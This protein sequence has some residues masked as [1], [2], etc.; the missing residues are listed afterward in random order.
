MRKAGIIAADILQEVCAQAKAGV[1]L[2]ELDDLAETLCY[3]NDV[4]PAFKGFEGF[5]NTLCVGVNDVVVHGIPSEY[6]LKDGDIVSIDFGI[7][8]KKVYSDTCYTV[9]VGK[10]SPEVEKFV[11]TVEKAMYAGI[12]QAIPGNTTGHIGH[13]VQTVVEAEGYS[14]VREMVGHGVG[15]EL[16]EMPDVP[17]WGEPGEG[18]RLYEGQTIAVEAIINMGGKEIVFDEEDGWTT[19]TKDGSLSGLFEHTI[20]VGKQPEILTKWRK[21]V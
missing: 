9:M 3:Q 10:V 17:N 15:Y 6:K 11:K 14:V 4:M 8:Y 5:P 21:V 12:A 13:A 20:I 18:D 2:L 1:T 16:H 7:E 19:R